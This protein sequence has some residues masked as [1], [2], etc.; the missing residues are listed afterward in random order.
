MRFPLGST[1]FYT[2]YCILD[3]DWLIFCTI[4]TCQLAEIHYL[5]ARSHHVNMSFIIYRHTIYRYYFS[6]KNVLFKV[7]SSKDILSIG[8]CLKCCFQGISFN[9]ILL[10]HFGC[11]H[12]P[13]SHFMYI[14]FLNIHLLYNHLVFLP[15]LCKP[16]ILLN[17][18]LGPVL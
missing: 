12:F 17:V 8:F 1:P 6:P 10:S 11:S 2:G 18:V 9:G 4:I 5:E 16:S 15:A 3:L 14:H 13:Q 7:I